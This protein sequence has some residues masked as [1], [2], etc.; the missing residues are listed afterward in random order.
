[1]DTELRQQFGEFALVACH[2]HLFV[3]PQRG[4]QQ[5]VSHRFGDRAGHTHLNSSGLPVLWVV[6]WIFR[7]SLSAKICSAHQGDAALVRQFQLASAFAKQ[8]MAQ[9]FLQLV[10]LSRQS[11]GRGVQLLTGGIT[12]PALAA[13]QK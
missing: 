1:V 5:M 4:L 7:L 13:A 11:L 3:H 9:P 12:P 2:V 8:F 10:D 6:G